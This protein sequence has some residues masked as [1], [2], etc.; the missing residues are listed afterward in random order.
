MLTAAKETVGA[1][2]I[3]QT[4]GTNIVASGLALAVNNSG[5]ATYNLS[6]GLLSSTV[7]GEAVTEWGTGI[8]TQSGGTNNTNVLDVTSP[9]IF[10]TSGTYNLN[11]GLLATSDL[12]GSPTAA[13]NFNGGTLQAS[14]AFSSSLPITLG[15]VANYRYQRI[16]DDVFRFPFRPGQPDQGG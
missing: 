5:Q 1:G 10:G 4:G 2:T 16:R 11:G 13:F 7:L 3:T 15:G 12:Y 9:Q 8:F 6:G 14:N